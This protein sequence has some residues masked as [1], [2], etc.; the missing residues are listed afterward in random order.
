MGAV[1]LHPNLDAVIE[2]CEALFGELQEP[3]AEANELVHLERRVKLVTAVCLLMAV[4]GIDYE[5]ACKDSDEDISPGAEWLMSGPRALGW[6][7]KGLQDH[8]VARGIRKAAGFQLTTD[9]E[10]EGK[11]RLEHI[12]M[13]KEPEHN[14]YCSDDPE[15]APGCAN[16]YRIRYFHYVEYMISD[17]SGSPLSHSEKT[18][19]FATI[20]IS[21]RV[22][23]NGT[24]VVSGRVFWPQVT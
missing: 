11:G 12:E 23:H 2:L 22:T 5:I 20:Y 19:N 9:L 18:L 6:H 8:W 17:Y 15:D 14:S 4:V 13:A 16:Q 24:V 1:K 21:E 3:D 7:L 10:E